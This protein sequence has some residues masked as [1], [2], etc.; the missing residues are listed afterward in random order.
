METGAKDD[1]PTLVFR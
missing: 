1:W